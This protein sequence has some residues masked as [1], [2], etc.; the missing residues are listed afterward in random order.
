MGALMTQVEE[1]LGPKLA[2]IEHSKSLS[3]FLD[4]FQHWRK[5]MRPNLS[6]ADDDSVAALEFRLKELAGEAETEQRKLA[7]SV[8][9]LLVDM[10]R[11]L[12]MPF[13]L[14][15]EMLPKLVRDLSR[16]Q[17][18][19]VA[20]VVEGGGIE[21]DRRIQDELRDVILHIIRNCIDHGIESPEERTQKGKSPR[22]TVTVTISEK[23]GNRV[24]I[25]IRD[26][27]RGIDRRALL[28]AAVK[29]GHVS[30][31]D[32]ETMSETEMLALAF[33]SGLSTSPLITD[34]SGRGLGLA[35]VRDRIDHLGG[36]L[37]IHSELGTG[38]TIHLTLPITM[39]AFRGI[40]V[41]VGDT[42]LIVPTLA[43]ERV[44]RVKPDTIQTVENRET[45]RVNGAAL[46]LARLHEILELPSKPPEIAQALVIG[47]GVNRMAVL[48]DEALSEQ[49]VIVKGFG[50]QLA[51]VRNISGAAVLGTGV[52]VPILNVR[53]VLNAAARVT[54]D[55]VP[56]ERPIADR[57][58]R[59]TVLLAEDS[60]TART[61]L[62]GILETAGFQVY[63]AVDGA[64]ALA[65][66][67]MENIDMVVSDIEMPRM[68]G[69]D[70]TAR[71]RSDKK[72]SKLPVVLVTALE[73]REDRERGMDVGA[74]AYIAKSSF[75][76]SNLL[77]VIHR[78][79]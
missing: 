13:N 11:V 32:A 2:A 49:E 45:L 64:E 41:R 20:L 9:T 15:H 35:I 71:I 50:L 42:R 22:G 59:R 51:R 66:A 33:Q 70:L 65:I 16:S 61:L 75:D 24:E 40:L 55:P 5:A 17:G 69:F 14:L 43:V 18:K 19:D 29:A 76:Q 34:V 21:V 74:N 60:I 67:R 6:P 48:V 52:V 36:N 77:E 26:D 1:M 58:D 56:A 23:S 30:M 39:A 31:S 63:T 3:A 72:L 37:K 78:L 68:N 28:K 7:G 38:T 27:G 12:M 62:K 54:R 57:R 46:S 10:K 4:D 25:Q 73:S 47:V 53:D 44:V 8:D 79:L